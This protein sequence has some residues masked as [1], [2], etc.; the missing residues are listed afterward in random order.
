MAPP[1]NAPGLWPEYPTL[2]DSRFK[3]SLN[4]RDE[5]IDLMLNSGSIS[6][7]PIVFLATPKSLPRTL[8][9]AAL[10]HLNQN[11]RINLKKRTVTLPKP[12]EI[13][14]KDFGD[15]PIA[16]LKRCCRYM[17]HK[18]AEDVMQLLASGDQSSHLLGI[19][20]NFRSFQ[21]ISHNNMQLVAS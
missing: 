6:F 5:R 14:S 4:V 12:C 18:R 16:V 11:V 10:L 21:F 19:E 3:H 7:P 2:S 17:D 20:V 8:Q 13:F 1:E 9:E 15:S